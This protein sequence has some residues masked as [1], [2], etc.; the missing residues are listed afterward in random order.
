MSLIK[1]LYLDCETSPNVVYSWRIGRRIDLTHDNIIEE[2]KIIT[3]CYKW[4]GK[5]EVHSLTWDAR[6]NDKAMLKSFLKVLMQA[7]EVVAHNGDRFDLPWI[8][9]RCLFHGIDIPAQLPSVDTLKLAK[10]GFLFNNNRLDYLGGFMGHGRKK[11]TGGYGLWIRVMNG[12]QK[13]LDAMVDYC[14]RDV[15]LLE[16]VHHTLYGYSMP[17]THLAVLTGGYKHHC[18]RC[19]SDNVV[20]NGNKHVTAAGVVRVQMRCRGCNRQWRMSETVARNEML[21]EYK[22]KQLEKGLG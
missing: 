1:R 19:A 20:R 11:E 18:P 10:K 12:D 13:A 15:E 9:T 2:R 7:E 14:Q 3:I 5:K 16:K 6:K 22:A 21:R 8:R 4:E 17:K